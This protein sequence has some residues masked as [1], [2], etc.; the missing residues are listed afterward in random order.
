M[1]ESH[2][3]GL[4]RTMDNTKHNASSTPK[5]GLERTARAKNTRTTI[6][7]SSLAGVAAGMVAATMGSAAGASAINSLGDAIGLG[8]A[9]PDSL[10]AFALASFSNDEAREIGERLADSD[11]AIT[12]SRAATD[13]EIEFMR[14]LAERRRGVTV[15]ARPINKRTDIF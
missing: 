9:K 10:S 3:T 5:A 11:Q 4:R 1:E 6:L 7:H 8:D 13:D 14:A 15:H 12:R 2:G